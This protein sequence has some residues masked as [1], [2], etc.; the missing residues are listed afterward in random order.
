MSDAYRDASQRLYPHNG[1]GEAAFVHA[2]RLPV[3]SI[4]IVRTFTLHATYASFPLLVSKNIKQENVDAYDYRTDS[5]LSRYI[6]YIIRKIVND[7]C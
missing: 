6:R 3:D 7:T 2:N 4:E 5:N 1:G